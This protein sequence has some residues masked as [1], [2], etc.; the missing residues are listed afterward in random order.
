[1][2]GGFM[3]ATDLTQQGFSGGLAAAKVYDTFASNRSG[4]HNSDA[5]RDR[6]IDIAEEGLGNVTDAQRRIEEI[7][8]R[9]VRPFTMCEVITIGA[10]GLLAVSGAGSLIATAVACESLKGVIIA[11]CVS[12]TVAPIYASWQ[13]HNG[14][15]K[16]TQ[17]EINKESARQVRL[18]KEQNDKL[19][20]END[21]LSLSVGTLQVQVKELALVKEGLTKAVASVGSIQGKEEEILAKIEEI[22]N[23]EM[24]AVM[25]NMQQLQDRQKELLAEQEE[26]H[27]KLQ[28]LQQREVDLMAAELKLHEKNESLSVEM[29]DTLDRLQRNDM[30]RK[31]Q[32]RGKSAWRELVFLVQAKIKETS[33]IVLDLKSLRRLAVQANQVAYTKWI[34]YEVQ[35]LITSLAS[36]EAVKGEYFSFIQRELAKID[37]IHK[38]SVAECEA[39]KAQVIDRV[40]EFEEVGDLYSSDEQIEAL[41]KRIE[42]PQVEEV[43]TFLKSEARASVATEV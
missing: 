7:E 17:I 13:V 21:R 3:D 34:V 8:R 39:F 15:L 20:E 5:E 24:K 35:E 28:A 22:C 11:G 42:K 19:T 23:E 10:L 6:I 14:R 31:Y 29:K 40:D 12:G 27:V 2:K 9:G 33:S 30:N 1:M 25:G 18:F 43:F 41:M 38:L 26:L 32:R 36:N 37:T 16:D 4:D